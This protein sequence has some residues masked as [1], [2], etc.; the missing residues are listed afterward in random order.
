[1]QAPC[2]PDLQAPPPAVA[3]VYED[4]YLLLMESVQMAP[5]PA[6]DERGCVAPLP[7]ADER[8]CVAPLGRRCDAW[9]ERHRDT[10]ELRDAGWTWD[11]DIMRER[12]GI[13]SAAPGILSA[14]PGI[15]SAALVILSRGLFFLGAFHAEAG[16]PWGQESQGP[17]ARA[18]LPLN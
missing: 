6:A 16:T 11:K 9:L 8:G 17:L 15:L 4:C 5:L 18:F 2:R 1:M 7:A 3:A 14:A 10:P 13:F 12:D